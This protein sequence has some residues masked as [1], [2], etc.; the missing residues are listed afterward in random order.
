M[1]AASVENSS[2]FAIDRR[3]T[4]GSSWLRNI[5]VRRFRQTV[6]RRFPL[7]LRKVMVRLL[8]TSGAKPLAMDAPAVQP[9]CVAGYLSNPSGIGEGGR[10]TGMALAGAVSRMQTRLH[11]MDLSL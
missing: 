6:W 11:T 4:L 3:R 1:V 8:F 10:L 7:A 5:Y 9:I 2:F